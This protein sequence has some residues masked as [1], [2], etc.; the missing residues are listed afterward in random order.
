MIII[1]DKGT[2]GMSIVVFVTSYRF[3]FFPLKTHL[4]LSFEYCDRNFKHLNIVVV[5]TY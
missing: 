4:N 5:I 3:G 2:F 1:V